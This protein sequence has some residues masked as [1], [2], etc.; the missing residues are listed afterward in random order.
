MSNG[1]F[2][3]VY[4]ISAAPYRVDKPIFCLSLYLLFVICWLFIIFWTF[5][6]LIFVCILSLLFPGMKCMV[7]CVCRFQYRCSCA[8]LFANVY[9]SELG[10]SYLLLPDVVLHLLP[11]HFCNPYRNT[12][13][14]ICFVF[15]LQ[16]LSLFSSLRYDISSFIHLQICI[17]R[18]YGSIFPGFCGTDHL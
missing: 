15:L 4:I 17:I 5:C 16:F 7:P 1:S 3:L 11:P 6:H 12:N 10:F 8:L 18:N 9:Y 13:T 2:L 14:Y